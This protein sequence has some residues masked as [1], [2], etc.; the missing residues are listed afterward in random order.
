[1]KVNGKE[2]KWEDAPK[3]DFVTDV[4]A[5]VLWRDEKTGANLTLLKAP[6]GKMQRDQAHL[7]PSANEW[8]VIFAGETELPDGTRMTASADNLYFGFFP[9]GLTH[10]GS[11]NKVN[12]EVIWLRYLDGP[13]A[14]INK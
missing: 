11:E 5:H 13:P 6:K 4:K 1:M 7:H 10:S 14:R 3:G 12:Q 8:T 9:K 2:I